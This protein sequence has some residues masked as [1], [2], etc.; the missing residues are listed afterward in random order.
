MLADIVPALEDGGEPGALVDDGPEDDGDEERQRD[1]GGVE[2][3]VEGPQRLR[4]AV[5]Q[6]P[7]G[8]GV[9]AGVDRSGEEVEGEAPVGED[10]EVGKGAAGGLAAALGRVGAVP[11]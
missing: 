2:E 8:Q 1:D 7:A 11:A 3:G 10:G 5:E 9:G 4:Q 6:R